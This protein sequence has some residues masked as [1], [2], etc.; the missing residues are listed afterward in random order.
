MTETISQI[1]R[2]GFE[3]WKSNL[4]ISCINLVWALIVTMILGIGLVSFFIPIFMAPPLNAAFTDPES[5]V[6]LTPDEISAMTVETMENLSPSDFIAPGLIFL[7]CLILVILAD[8][9]V[10]GGLYA[11]MRDATQNGK[12]SYGTFLSEGRK[13]FLRVAVAWIISLIFILII[14]VIVGFIAGIVFVIV[15]A[16]FQAGG[17]S[18]ESFFMSP[19]FTIVQIPITFILIVLVYPFSFLIYGVVI[20]Q[21]QK[22]SEA[23][24]TTFSFI[25]HNLKDELTLG[26]IIGCLTGLIMI[27]NLIP[28]ISMFTF[29]LMGLVIGPLIAFWSVRL[30]MD[31]RDMIGMPDACRSAGSGAGSAGYAG[32]AGS[33]CSDD[34]LNED[35]PSCQPETAGDAEK[36]YVDENGRIVPCGPPDYPELGG[37]KEL[38]R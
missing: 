30:Y 3:T 18:P 17:A 21:D 24:K 25:R 4:G 2:S 13:N 37:Y 28:I 29:L 26:V 31:R 12:C 8:F 19:L 34:G 5:F 10:T 38:K 14:S 20:E 22:L 1:I 9:F 11:M 32:S 6:N 7:I 35:D 23:L 16:V 33:C 27:I 36:V 15:A